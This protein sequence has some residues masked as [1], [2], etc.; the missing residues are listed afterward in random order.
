MNDSLYI[1]ATGLQAQQTTLDAI[2]NNLANVSTVGFKKGRANF[3]EL[4]QA[5]PSD[6]TRRSHA[7][8]GAGISLA[9]LAR[10][11]A[12]GQLAQTGAPLDLAIEGAGFIEVTLADGS[13]GYTRAG[14]LSVTSDGYLAAA[15]GRVI[16]PSIHVPG[17]ATDLQITADGKVTAS[18]AA[19]QRIEIGQ[20]DLAYFANPA[21]L[22]SSTSGV[23]LPTEA[24]GQAM[25]AKPGSQGLGLLRQGALEGSNVNLVDEMVALMQAQRAYE[26]SSK[27]IQVSDELMQLTNNLRR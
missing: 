4:M 5:D 21:A 26:M 9:N 12:S 18:G 7:P 10:D 24:S 22:Q 16:R 27:V 20:L 2:A 14:K 6:T 19:G 8:A 11:F 23:Y 25:T 17:S 15:D 13:L 3:Q 1:A